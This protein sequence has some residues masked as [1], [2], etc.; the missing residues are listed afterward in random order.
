MGV[1]RRPHT[2]SGLRAGRSS[3]GLSFYRIYIEIFHIRVYYMKKYRNFHNQFIVYIN[4]LAK[5]MK[6]VFHVC[7]DKNGMSF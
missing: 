3:S 5:R 7:D 2:R 4:A 1:S 6:R